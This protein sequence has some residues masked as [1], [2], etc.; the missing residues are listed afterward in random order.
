MND[1]LVYVV[2]TMSRNQGKERVLG[3]TLDEDEA[4]SVCD[5]KVLCGYKELLLDSNVVFT[6]KRK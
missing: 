3:Y 2:Y 4:K 1:V 6:M 5:E